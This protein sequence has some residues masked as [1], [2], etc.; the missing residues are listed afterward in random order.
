MLGHTVP[1]HFLGLPRVISPGRCHLGIWVLT[2]PAGAGHTVAFTP[3]H[4][5]FRIYSG[6]TQWRDFG[7]VFFFWFLKINFVEIKSIH[8]KC[9]VWLLWYSDRNLPC[10]CK[11]WVWSP[12]LGR[13]HASSGAIKP[14]APQLLSLN[15]RAW[16]LQILRPC[17]YKACAPQEK[18]LQ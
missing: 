13:S 7:V 16:E 8:L 15:S 4:S 10:Q 3:S 6:T 17:A 9:T 5:G 11:A 2:S 1:H 12:D 18:P 14:C